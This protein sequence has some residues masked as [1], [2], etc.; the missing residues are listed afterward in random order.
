VR[1][2]VL[3]LFPNGFPLGG[4]STNR[5]LHIAKII[6]LNSENTAKIL[7]TGGT[8][9][10]NNIL[11]KNN[12]GY[13][14]GVKYRYAL[15]STLWPSQ[16]YLKLINRFQG[17][18]KTSISIF[19]SSSKIV[20]AYAEYNILVIFSYYCVCRLSG[21]KF[22]YVVDE[23]PWVD[24]FNKNYSKII[25]R[26]Y[27]AF[28]YKMFDGIVVMTKILKKYYSDKASKN[29]VFFHLPMTVDI[30]RFNV[31]NETNLDN[32]R[33]V[34]CGGGGTSKNNKDGIDILLKSFS[35]FVEKNK[36]GRLIL[37]GNFHSAYHSYVEKNNLNRYVEFMGWVTKDEIP[38]VLGSGNVLILS[39]P[40]SLQ[41]EGGF[42]TK[43]GEY[44]ATG[45][46]VLV[47]KTGEISN[48]LENKI[49]AYLAEPDSVESIVNNLNFIYSNYKE[50]QKV[51][52]KGKEI[53]LTNF[54]YNRYA[55][56]FNKFLI[57]VEN[58]K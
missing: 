19:R 13:Y 52:Q 4:S 18:V 55:I 22:I 57:E 43:L 58:E 46:P 45:I 24:I 2:E 48:Y 12:S 11:N 25:R 39:R 36:Q 15:Y 23:Y 41:A 31:K 1:R 32:F 56:S 30:S 8:E 9:K 34:Y 38:R 7:I 21:K 42:P 49:S 5:I 53:A 29:T 40:S 51:G 44:L 47:T 6:N 17:M 37:V 26:L 35:L 14:E 54:D 33:I 10:E 20:I 27:K 28:F 3:I 50:A 16:S